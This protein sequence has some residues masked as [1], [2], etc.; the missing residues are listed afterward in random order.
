L[1]RADNTLIESSDVDDAG[2]PIFDRPVG[3]GFVIVVEAAAGPSRARPGDSTFDYDPQDASLLPD[4]QVESNRDLGD[5]SSAVCDTDAEHFGGVPGLN[6][7]HSGVSN[8]TLAA[9][10]N[11]SA[12][13]S[14]TGPGQPMAARDQR[15]HPLPDAD[16][17]FAATTTQVQFSRRWCARRVSRRRRSHGAGSRRARSSTGAADRRPRRRVQL[18]RAWCSAPA[19]AQPRASAAPAAEPRTTIAP[20]V[21]AAGRPASRGPLGYPRCLAQS[22]SSSA[23]APAETGA[24]GANSPRFSPPTRSDRAA[25]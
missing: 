8:E 13:V 3:S 17:R 19:A 6:P 14:S 7:D 2:R 15:P 16:F 12:V 11:D 18:T 21:R 5:G 25:A 20:A 1:L 24:P 22:S 4:L 23:A 9:T 10:L